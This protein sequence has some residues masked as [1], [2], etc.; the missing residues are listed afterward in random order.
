[1]A[2]VLIDG[3]DVY[4]GIV[5]NTGIQ[6]KWALVVTTNLSMQTGRFGGQCCQ[7]IESSSGTRGPGTRGLPSAYTSV[8]IGFAFR[9]TVAVTSTGVNPFVEFLSGTTYQL[10][11]AVR[12]S[13]QL[14]FYRL[15]SLTAG[16]LLGSSATGVIVLNQ[17]HYIEIGVAISDTVGTVTVKVDGTTVITLTGQDTNN[18]GGNVNVIAFQTGSNGGTATYQVDDIYV[19]DSATTLGER[20]IE[21]LYPTSDVAQG[22]TRSAGSDNYALVDETQVNGDTDYVQA[23]V[24]NTVDTYGFQDVTGSPATIDAVQVSAFAEKTDAT[25]RSIALQVKSGATTSDGSNFGL[26]ASYAKFERLL[27]TD[28]NGGGSWSASAVNAL[29]GGPK[30]TV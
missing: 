21:T 14:D 20:R 18:S 17:W 24:V 25:A 22:W 15:T 7:W 29:Q 27:T 30:V 9:L 10:G 26:N 4:N 5:T 8:G 19:V 16:T 12:S 11:M 1:M 6:A 2:V 23:S 3:L 13:G 28:P